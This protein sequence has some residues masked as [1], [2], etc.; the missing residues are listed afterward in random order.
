VRIVYFGTPEFAVPSLE[1]LHRAGHEILL[2]VSRPD[3][4][5]GRRLQVSTPAVAAYAGRHGLPLVQPEKAGA[6]EFYLPFRNLAPEAAVVVAYGKLISP[7]LLRVPARGFINVHPSLL[8]RHRGPS[9]V[10]WAIASGD[11]ETGVSTMVLDEGMDTGPVLLQ[12]AVTIHP[13][14]RTGQ[15]EERL[16]RLGAELLVETLSGLQA[17]TVGP[18]PQDDSAATVT[19]KLDRKMARIEWSLPAAQLALRCRA[20]DPWPGLFCT[21]RGARVKIHGLD[22]SPHH[23]GGAAPGTVLACAPDGITV[24]CGGETQALLTEL[25]R[26][27]KRRLPADAFLLGERVA[28][29]ERFR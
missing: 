4:P 5:A 27:G 21:F 10:A 1:A 11:A 7:R 16:A 29:G 18:Q 20:F 2:V 25:Q 24:Q 12:R 9:P 26:E 6:D 13:R 19:P 23:G 14:E 3:R 8:P 22:V 28:P 17:G 15:L